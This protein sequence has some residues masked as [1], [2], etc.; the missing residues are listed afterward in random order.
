MA[1]CL[2]PVH[3]VKNA[4]IMVERRCFISSLASPSPSFTGATTTFRQNE[5][6]IRN[7]SEGDQPQTNHLHL[8]QPYT[9]SRALPVH[10]SSIILFGQSLGTA[11]VTGTTHRWTLTRVPLL[12]PNQISRLLLPQRP[13]PSD[14]PSLKPLPSLKALQRHVYR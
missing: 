6:Q 9:H 1:L 7:H 2:A 14:P 13:D 3:Q 11:V 10:P 4:S 12:F 8:S 5:E